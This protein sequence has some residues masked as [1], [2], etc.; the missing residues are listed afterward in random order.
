MKLS[1]MDWSWAWTQRYFMVA[2]AIWMVSVLT[3]PNLDNNWIILSAGSMA[4][5]SLPIIRPTARV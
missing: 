4:L 3:G 5:L 2:G 1:W